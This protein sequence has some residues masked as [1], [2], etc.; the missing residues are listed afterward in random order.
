MNKLANHDKQYSIADEKVI[1][2]FIKS[3][4]SLEKQ[5]MNKKKNNR[6]LLNL[7][8]VK[9][10]F[11]D[12]RHSEVQI[13]SRNYDLTKRKSK[14]KDFYISSAHNKAS[15]IPNDISGNFNAPKQIIKENKEKMS[16]DSRQELHSNTNL[17]ISCFSYNSDSSI[18]TNAKELKEEGSWIRPKPQSISKVNDRGKMLLRQKFSTKQNNGKKFVKEDGEYKQSSRM[19][20]YKLPTD[21]FY[22]KEHN[23]FSEEVGHSNSESTIINKVANVCSR[24]HSKSDSESN[25]F[26]SSSLH[27]DILFR[28]DEV[29]KQIKE[30]IPVVN[31]KSNTKEDK[32]ISKSVIAANVAKPKIKNNL[33]I[34]IDE[35]RCDELKVQNRESSIEDIF[36][37]NKVDSG[38]VDGDKLIFSTG[39]NNLLSSDNNPMYVSVPNEIHQQINQLLKTGGSYASR[40]NSNASTTKNCDSKLFNIFITNP[41]TPISNAIIN[42]DLTHQGIEDLGYKSYNINYDNTN[43]ILLLKNVDEN[44]D[45]IFYNNENDEESS[46][47][48]D[49]SDKVLYSVDKKNRIFYLKSSQI[50]SEITSLI[51]SH[52]SRIFSDKPTKNIT[53]SQSIISPKH[54]TGTANIDHEKIVEKLKIVERMRDRKNAGFNSK[55]NSS[56]NTPKNHLQSIEGMSF[57]IQTSLKKEFTSNGMNTGIQNN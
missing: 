25:Q 33:S 32:C 43:K 41:Q 35:Y 1:S 55:L 22:V 10:G 19:K 14:K 45:L 15:D 30:E 54:N 42:H 17:S 2:V 34:K 50:I 56:L 12:I 16:S 6:R 7:F 29:V 4:K 28:V 13:N 36:T 21:N 26:E 38:V 20:K 46:Q 5:Q 51:Q 44:K 18:Y 11:N 24:L 31:P 57:S 39:I 48:K 23:L 37:I 27:L 49:S 47:D 9:V 8:S 3:L 53:E 52:Q 40:C